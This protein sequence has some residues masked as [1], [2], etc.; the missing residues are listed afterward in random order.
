MI[1]AGQ[2]GPGDQLPPERTLAELFGVGRNSIREAI[3]QLAALGLVEA[4]QGGGTFVLASDSQA[5]VRPFRSVVELSSTTPEQMFEFRLI[6]EPPMASI[7]SEERRGGK[8]CRS[9]WSAYH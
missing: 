9:R 6:L 5:L 8:E 2:L 1:L 7:R 3:R 4:Y